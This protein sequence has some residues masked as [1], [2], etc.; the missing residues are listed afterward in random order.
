MD[1]Q[2]PVSRRCSKS[3]NCF[4]KTGTA[5]SAGIIASSDCCSVLPTYILK[6]THRYIVSIN[7]SIMHCLVSLG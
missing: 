6:P 4:L 2:P 5:D 3:L 1:L 7:T